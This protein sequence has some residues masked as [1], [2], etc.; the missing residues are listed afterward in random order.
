M[1]LLDYIFI[2]F[3]IWGALTGWR[4]GFLAIV[5]GFAGV[6]L[7]WYLAARYSPAA[8]H[9]IDASLGWVRGTGRYLA[10]RVPLS[11]SLASYSLANLRPEEVSRLLAGLPFPALLQRPLAD[12]AMKVLASAASLHLSTLGDLIYY[13][14]ALLIWTVVAFFVIMAVTTGLANSVAWGVTRSLEGTPL[15][16]FNHLTGA[17]LGSAENL[18]TLVVLAGLLTPVLHLLRWPAL[19]QF[20]TASKFLPTLAAWFQAWSPWKVV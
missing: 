9:W 1:S 6:L 20:L 3:L 19:Q 11:S 18:V 5:I 12:A 8:A 17:V 4:R 16:G 2:A 10:T 13:S 7:A 14:M 15:S